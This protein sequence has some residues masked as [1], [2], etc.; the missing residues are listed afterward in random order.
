MIHMDLGLELRMRRLLFKDKQPLRKSYQVF[1]DL[2][3]TQAGEG[4]GG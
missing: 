2:L 1:G 3:L 4:G